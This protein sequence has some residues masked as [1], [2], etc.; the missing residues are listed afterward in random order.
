[1]EDSSRVAKQCVRCRKIGENNDLN[2]VGALY[3]KGQGKKHPLETIIEQA[4]KVGDQRLLDN[5]KAVQENGGNVHIHG[6]CW[7]TLRNEKVLMI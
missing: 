3:K 6:S 4:R 2:Q 5:I 1:M 7:T